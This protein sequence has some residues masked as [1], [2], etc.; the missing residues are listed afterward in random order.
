[1]KLYIFL[2]ISFFFTSCSVIN[3]KNDKST[4]VIKFMGTVN[5]Y[6]MAINDDIFWE[7]PHEH[8][9]IKMNYEFKESF[10]DSLEIVNKDINFEN[11]T[12]AFIYYN[13]GKRDTIYADQSLK[14]Y[15]KIIR[16]KNKKFDKYYFYYDTSNKFEWFRFKYSFFNECW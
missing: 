14:N 10:V 7:N 8:S 9:I 11:L 3:T 12:Y 1:M 4:I 13:L 16:G 6:P 2:A 5:R 15:Y